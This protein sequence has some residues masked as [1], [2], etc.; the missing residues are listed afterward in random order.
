MKVI[1]IWKLL[2]GVCFLIGL[3]SCN[4]EELPYYGDIAGVYFNGASWSYSFLEDPSKSL[5]TLKVPVL[6]TGMNKDY[7]RI[8]QVEVIADSTSAPNE[9][10]Q[11]LDGR[12][13]AGKFEGILPVV[14]HKADIL[15]DT[16]FRIVVKLIPTEDFSEFR[17]GRSFYSV[18]FTAKLIQ[19]A[20]WG[21]LKYYFGD[22]STLW[23]SKII[24][25]TG[26][27]SLPY[28]PTHPDKETWWMPEYTLRVYQDL[29][30][31]RL[32]EY[33][34]E[35]EHQDNPLTHNDGEKAGLPVSMP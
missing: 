11:I 31:E 2:L 29:V 9:L 27:G 13:E 23:W 14:V 4:K 1:N 35:L 19:P 16:I 24:E 17:M 21:W 32:T 20:N 6:I 34:A 28:Y 22:F 10:Y 12:V 5:D 7:E 3:A 30:R 18:K 33:N 25:W 26:R 15:S 8:F